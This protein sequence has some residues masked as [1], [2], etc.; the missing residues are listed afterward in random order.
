MVAS[1]AFRQ[2]I[3]SSLVNSVSEMMTTFYGT[4]FEALDMRLA[5][6]LGH[7]FERAGSEALD[8]TQLELALELGKSSEVISHLLKKLERR[9]WIILSSGKINIGGNRELPGG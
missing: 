5:C 1:Q 8:I 6:L 9:E 3:L 4:T 2:R 7:L